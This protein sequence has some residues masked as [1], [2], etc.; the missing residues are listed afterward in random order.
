[1][2]ADSACFWRQ[3][4]V[5]CL[6]PRELLAYAACRGRSCSPA[7][8]TWQRFGQH[9]LAN[10]WDGRMHWEGDSLVLKAT[11]ALH[12]T[13]W[14]QLFGRYWDHG[15]WGGEL[16]WNRTHIPLVWSRCYIMAVFEACCI[17]SILKDGVKLKIM[18]WMSVWKELL[19]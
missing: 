6:T 3:W 4:A 10:S 13:V 11:M 9:T 12:R 16:P 5:A 8:L 1:M 18:V 15:V 17:N 19:L 2:Q 14:V 7:F